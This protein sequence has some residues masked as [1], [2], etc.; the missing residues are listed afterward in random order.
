MKDVLGKIQTEME[1]QIKM[2]NVL[3]RLDYQKNKDALKLMLISQVK[4]LRLLKTFYS[5]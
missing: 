1:F 4:L 2:T 3:L 5:T